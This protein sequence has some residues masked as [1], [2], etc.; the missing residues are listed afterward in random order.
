MILRSTPQDVQ[1][2]LRPTVC[3][4][5]AGAAGITLACELDNSGLD[6]LLL[7]PG[8]IKPGASITQAP[9]QGSTTP[10]SH[11]PADHF[12]RRGYGGT[13]TIWGG[14]CVPYDPIDFELRPHVP[15]SGWPISYEDVAK[16]YPKAMSY[17]EAGSNDFNADHIFPYRIPMLPDVDDNADLVTNIVER[18]SLPTDFGRSHHHRLQQSS[19]V[20][21]LGG[22]Q[23]LELLRTTEGDRIGSVRCCHISSGQ[24]FDIQA[25]QVVLA[26]GGIETPRLLLA[27]DRAHGGIGNAHD[28]VGRYYTCHVGKIHGVLRSKKPVQTFHFETTLDGVY[29]RRKILIKEDVQRRE[30]L[31]NIAFRLHYPDVSLPSHRSS[32]LSAVY[33]AKRTLIPEYSRILEHSSSGAA[34]S[35]GAHLRNVLFGLPEL[36]MFGLNWIHKRVLPRRKLPYVL[37][38]NAD[39]SYPIAFNAEQVPLHD[40]R[41]TLGQEVDEF[42]VPRVHID[43]KMCKEDVESATRAYRILKKSLEKSGTCSVEFDEA[44]LHRDMSDMAAVGGHHIGTTR[45]AA[46][47]DKGVVDPNCQVFGLSNLYVTGSAVFPTCSHANPTLTIVALAVRLAE[48]LQRER[49]IA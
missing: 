43:W 39:H 48:H 35:V 18:Y 34:P 15:G 23:V 46:S 25:H 41:I 33:L 37:I 27:S 22:V 9:Y 32:V 13:T 2:H 42:G 30:G 16:H 17:L 8:P 20:A 47:P 14:R 24:T 19:N 3:I 36:G 45:M 4:I 26:M 29:A 28:L 7:D 38:A 44:S 6:V 10:S 11:P 21:V 5:G 40:S 49:S 12:R 31:L 1:Q